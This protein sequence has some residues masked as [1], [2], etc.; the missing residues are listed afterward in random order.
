MKRTPRLMAVAVFAMSVALIAGSAMAQPGGRGRGGPGG[1]GGPGGFGGFGMRAPGGGSGGVL[2]LLRAEVVRTEVGIDEAT[3]E[4][5]REVS[6]EAMEAGRGDF[7]GFRELSE[8]QRRARMEE[9]RAQWQ[10]R[11]KAQEKKVE[12]VVGTEKFGRLKEIELQ[13]AGVEALTREDVGNFLKLT[14]EQKKQIT[15]IMGANQEAAREK[16]EAALP[17][18]FSAMRDM[19]EAARRAAFEKMGAIRTELRKEMETKLMGVLTDEQKENLGKMMG[20]PFAKMDELREQLRAE[21][22]RGG[23]RGGDRGPGARGDRGGDRGDRGGDRGPRGDGERR[24][25]RPNA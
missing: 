7:E 5:V 25:R 2:N 4:K 16:M 9:M 22:G 18:G 24:P 8:E 1:P 15:D 3:Y 20:Q 17:G 12:E 13:M 10:E 11:M 21:F 19:D 6:R 14:E 23:D